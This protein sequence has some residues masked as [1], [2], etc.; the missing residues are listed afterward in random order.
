MMREPTAQERKVLYASETFPNEAT[1][2]TCAEVFSEPATARLSLDPERVERDLARLVLSLVELLRQVL[3]KQAMR[4]VEGGSL[5]EEDIERLGLTFLRLSERMQELKTTF[6]LED[7]DLDLCL[8]LSG[9]LLQDL[10]D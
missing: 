9:D 8:G 7:K 1:A 10:G 2:E 3:E 4:R 5:Q 6:G